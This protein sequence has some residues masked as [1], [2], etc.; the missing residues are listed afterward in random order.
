MH[1]FVTLALHLSPGQ[2]FVLLS[3][4]AREKQDHIDSMMHPELYSVSICPV[5][6]KLYGVWSF[7]N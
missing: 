7:E 5:M 3:S 6:P 1:P 4:V 2:K